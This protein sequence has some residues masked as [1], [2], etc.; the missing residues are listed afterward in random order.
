MPPSRTRRGPRLATQR[1]LYRY[2]LTM[3]GQ[4]IARRHTL[5]RR[6]DVMLVP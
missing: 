5:T 3:G 1:R 2:A 4:L 6:C